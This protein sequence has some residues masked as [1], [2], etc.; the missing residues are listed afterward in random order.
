M[1][2][3][4][5]LRSSRDGQTIISLTSGQGQLSAVTQD[6]NHHRDKQRSVTPP[7][8]MADHSSHTE[9]KGILMIAAARTAWPDLITHWHSAAAILFAF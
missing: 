2:S 5:F 9:R 1:G 8:L 4:G 6:L 7:C 3:A